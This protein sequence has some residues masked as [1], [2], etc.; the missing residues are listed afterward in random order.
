M[1]NDL[2]APFLAA[3]AA[4][5]RVP[6]QLVVFHF[7]LLGDVYL[8]DRDITVNGIL[9]K[10]LVENWGELRTSGGLDDVSGTMEMNLTIWNG[11]D[12]PFSEFFLSE[13]PMNVFVDIYQ[14]FDGLAPE[15]MAIIGHFVIQDPIEYSENSRLLSLDLVTTNMR[16]FAQV[17]SLLT[18]E[19]FPYALESDVNKPIGLIVGDCGFVSALCSSTPPRCTQ[20]GSILKLPTIINV[21]EDLDG[22][23]FPSTGFIQIDAEILAYSS[24]TSTSFTI[25]IRGYGASIAVDHSDGSEIIRAQVDI[26]YIVGQGPIDSITQ[27]KVKGQVPT[28]PYTVHP[29]ENPAVIR[30]QEQ[31]TY[32]EFSRGA[33]STDV[34][35]D[36]TAGDNTAYQPHYAYDKVFRSYGAII[37][38]SHRKLSILQQDSALDDGEV[39]RVFLALEHWATKV[40]AND[41]CQVFVDGLFLGNLSKPNPSDIITIS[42]DVDIDHPHDHITGGIHDHNFGNPGLDTYNPSHDHPTSLTSEVKDGSSTGLPYSIPGYSGGSKTFYYAGQYNVISKSIFINFRQLGTGAVTLSWGGIFTGGSISWDSSDKAVSQNVNVPASTTSV[43]LSVASSGVVGSYVKVYEITLTTIKTGY[44]DYRQTA[45]D[46]SHTSTGDVYNQGIDTGSI[47]IKDKGDVDSLS[48]ANRQLE[49]IA[50]TTSS[51]PVLEKFDITK[52]LQNVSW[53]WLQG[54]D[55]DI[56][57]QGS[58]NNA[59]VV[60]TYAYFEVEYRQKQIRTTDDVSAYVVGSIESRPDAVIQYLLTEKAKVPAN[61][62]GSVWR[63]IPIWYDV[64]VWDDLEIWQDEGQVA[65]VPFGALFEEAS[66]WFNFR[67]YTIDGVVKGNLSV[68]DAIVNLT[69]QTRSKLQWQSGLAKLVILRKT[70]NWAIAKELGP[71]ILQLRS[72]SAERTVSSEIINKIDLFYDLDKLSAVE[73]EGAYNKTAYETDIVSINKNGEKKG[74]SLF[75]FD[76]IRASSMAEDIVDYYIWLFGET[77]TLYGFNTYLPNFDIEKSDYVSISSTGFGKLNKLPVTIRDSIRIFGSGKNSSINKISMLGESIR[78]KD[79]ID[80]E[81]DYI[82]CSDNLDIDFG[83][84]LSFDDIVNISDILSINQGKFFEDEVIFSD[85][86]S[87]LSIFREQPEETIITQDELSAHH[88]IVLDD[89][90]IINESFTLAQELCWGA[91]GWGAPDCVGPVWG[92]RTT[93]RDFTSEYPLILD[94]LAMLDSINVTE[95]DIVCSD[96]LVFSDGWGCPTGLGSGFGLSPWGDVNYSTI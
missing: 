61:K 90:V 4:E 69:F 26:E 55:I 93:H 83:T 65:G 67:S 56:I 38:K 81:E 91:C 95:E 63:S 58:A 30:F 39:V 79:F 96:N 77:R 43:K 84:D 23:L 34:D 60:I 13:D 28:V 8:S 72:L 80:F 48:I 1:R 32:T 75:M 71:E 29:E 86:L 3:M 19:D 41:I 73:G 44:I 36:A 49:N 22:L 54:K 85:S 64:E 62:L 89:E 6:I 24:R 74:D 87:S 14:T 76:L 21:L 82:I 78:H 50:T 92:S 12:N 15:D 37:D 70:D 25:S 27:V 45:I 9:Y 11:G 51:K 66:A 46:T 59:Q 68:K 5:Y 88:K 20:S 35:F 10:G 31:P 94:T 53:D 57:Y 2:T 40:Y 7:V 52:H 16:Y 33:R 18:L 42:G 47:P 17:G